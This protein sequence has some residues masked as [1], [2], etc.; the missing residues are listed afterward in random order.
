MKLWYSLDGLA[1]ISEFSVFRIATNV[2]QLVEDF[3]PRSEQMYH[4]H[5][6]NWPK[7]T[8][9]SFKTPI[10]NFALFSA[11]ATLLSGKY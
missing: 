11:S 10:S 3:H 9:S 5:Q 2:L 1:N 6:T 4:L 7:E 8:S